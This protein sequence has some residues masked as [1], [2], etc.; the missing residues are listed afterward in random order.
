MDKVFMQLLTCSLSM[1]A[2]ALLAAILSPQLEKR[3][4]R[5]GLYTLWLVI[6]LGFIIPI[7]PQIE[8]TPAVTITVPSTVS[9]P[10]DLP[11]LQIRTTEATTRVQTVLSAQEKRLSLPE[12][13]P[14]QALLTVWLAGALFVLAQQT[15]CHMRF[16]RTVRRWQRPVLSRRALAVYE[17]ASAEMRVSCTPR[18]MICPAVKSPMLV[19]FFSPRILLP[20][21]FEEN[22]ALAMVLRHELAHHVQHDLLVRML[23]LLARAM[24]W[25]NPAAYLC[26]RMVD[27]YCELACD[28]RAMNG[29]SREARAAYGGVLIDCLRAGRFAASPLTTGFSLDKR[30]LKK[31]LID[32]MDMR[33][34]KRGAWFAVIAA[35]LCAVVG[36]GVVLA[37]QTEKHEPDVMQVEYKNAPQIISKFAAGTTLDVYD[38]ASNTAWSM[39]VI[40]AEGCGGA[41]VLC[42]EPVG[43]W[44][45]NMGCVLDLEPGA[46]RAVWITLPD[47]S[48]VIAAVENTTYAGDAVADNEFTGHLHIHFPDGGGSTAQQAI[49][50]GWAQTKELTE[51]VSGFDGEAMTIEEWDAIYKEVT[52]RMNTV[53]NYRYDADFIK[54]YEAD[55]KAQGGEL[56][57]D[58]IICMLPGEKDMP[59]ETALEYAYMLIEQKYGIP[60]KTLEAMGAYPTF[61]EYPYM[62]LES[63]WEFYITPRRD[64]DLSLDHDYPPE[65]E[66]RVTFTSRTGQVLLCVQYLPDGQT[67]PAPLAEEAGKK[68]EV[69]PVRAM[70][71]TLIDALSIA[72]EDFMVY[73]GID[74]ETYDA[75]YVECV[76]SA[77]E[78]YAFEL[79][80]RED[81][82]AEWAGQ[83]YAYGVSGETGE[84][85]YRQVS[86]CTI[87][88]LD[89]NDVI[90]DP[91]ASTFISEGG[92]DESGGVIRLPRLIDWI[93]P[94]RKKAEEHA[95]GIMMAI[96]QAADAVQMD[97]QDMAW[98]DED[99]LALTL[100]LSS[101]RNIFVVTER[102][103]VNGFEL[104]NPERND[105]ENSWLHNPLEGEAGGRE[106]EIRLHLEESAFAEKGDALAAALKSIRSGGE[107]AIE[108]TLSLLRP[109]NGLALIDT[110]EMT[111]LSAWTQIDDAVQNGL[112][113]IDSE[114]WT[115][116]PASSWMGEEAKNTRSGEVP[117]QYPLG[118]K[119]TIIDHANMVEA[120]R[121]VLKIMEE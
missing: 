119:Q 43:D 45:W 5:R 48:T 66:Y 103:T 77:V 3:Y 21:D 117:V 15:A 20:E 102:V 116:L 121:I 107:Y 109:E 54:A 57:E 2:L 59:Y 18:L 87:G 37:E 70:D 96:V 27:H 78:S 98:E 84:V 90:Y 39:Q 41:D 86:T 79:L 97:V 91:A 28:E 33:G 42:A 115:V 44:Y 49:E 89:E 88:A 35:L 108:I 64:C 58:M 23:S 30:M 25:F 105:L 114:P 47:G 100:S 62:N 17:Q 68:P 6:L 19:G 69:T 82:P 118:D 71:V 51:F 4:A 60:R 75:L 101:T 104:I 10:I 22:A 73:K 14:A 67:T 31:R 56:K 120:D 9:Q 29:V 112:T 61:Y 94:G 106:A 26:L 110:T 99:T 7:R 74:R 76:A 85:L 13:T 38:Y 63:E 12:I 36:A 40:D 95:G 113:P 92:V 53:M 16:M 8:K 32:M 46:A 111:N 52:T 55:V 65:G 81:A 80:V 24:H 50:E 1:T 11:A 72:R 83:N 34:K 93:V